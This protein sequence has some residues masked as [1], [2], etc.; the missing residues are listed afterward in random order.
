GEVLIR[1][2]VDDIVLV[3]RSLDMLENILQQLRSVMVGLEFKIENPGNKP[4]Q[5]LDL[6]L[7]GGGK[8][9]CWQ[10]GSGKEKPLLHRFS[11]H[12]KLVKNGM[13]LSCIKNVFKKS[14]TH[15]IG[16]A[17]SKQLDRLLLAGYDVDFVCSVLMKCNFDV[18]ALTNR[19]FDKKNVIVVP[20]I[21]KMSHGLLGLVKDYG[22]K[23]VFSVPFKLSC[24]TPFSDL[25][26]AFRCWTKHRDIGDNCSRNVVYKIPLSCGKLYVGQTH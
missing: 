7:L 21:H 18:Q 8:S 20:Y 13:I 22:L 23:I 17:F 1:R 26:H 5:F 12:S 15:F 24:L 2:F 10:Y 25:S 19:P 3:G 6:Q 14:C 4:L 11:Q 9:L 16:M